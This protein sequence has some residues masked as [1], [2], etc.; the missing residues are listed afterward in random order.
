[1]IVKAAEWPADKVTAQ[2]PGQPNHCLWTLGHLAST[3][4]WA[5]GVLDGKPSTL[6]EAY[7]KMFGMG[8]TPSADTKANPSLGEVR[9][10]FDQSW[11]R[12]QRIAQSMTPSQA[13]ESVKEATQG[14]ADTKMDLLYKLA[15]HDG[16]HL[17]QLTTLRKY[18][19]LPALLS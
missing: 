2:A 13:E 12:I 16:W 7:G 15:W 11:A 19:G 14:F 18:L 3:Y 8:S 9:S 1:M 17:G 4:D 10:H 6:P 5:A